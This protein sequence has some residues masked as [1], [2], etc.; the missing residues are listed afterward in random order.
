MAKAKVYNK[1]LEKLRQSKNN[2][3]S[4]KKT[5]QGFFPAYVGEE[6]KKYMIPVSCLSS[7]MFKALLNQFDQENESCLRPVCL[8]CSVWMFEA[9]LNLAKAEKEGTD[10]G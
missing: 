10:E 2:V 5:P 6:C 1:L 4:K 7:A 8:S 3:K 9:I